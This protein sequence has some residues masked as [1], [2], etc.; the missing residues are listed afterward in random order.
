MGR[1]S[2]AREAVSQVSS[3]FCLA[4]ALLRWQPGFLKAFPQAPS[5][6]THGTGRGLQFLGPWQVG[7]G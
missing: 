6:G 4:S 2:L 5:H 1:G 7:A 3:A